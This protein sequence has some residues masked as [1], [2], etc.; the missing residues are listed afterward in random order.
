MK[1]E[2][3]DSWVY[4]WMGIGCFMLLLL[5]PFLSTAVDR[6][7]YYTLPMQLAIW[8]RL[9]FIMSHDILKIYT[10]LL[11]LFTYL[12]ILFVWLNFATHSFAWIPYKTIFG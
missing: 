3:P 10:A 11:V 8:P 2:F 4:L 12:M 5:A 9:I 6:L 1:K 7:A